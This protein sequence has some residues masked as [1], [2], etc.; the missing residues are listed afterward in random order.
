MSM[1]ALSILTP[2]NQ[3]SQSENDENI[4]QKRESSPEE[5]HFNFEPYLSPPIQSK[6]GRIAE[7]N[8][9]QRMTTLERDIK[10]FSETTL[11][12]V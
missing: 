2:I 11:K 3:F 10:D 5:A 4:P 1:Y 9:D 8:L 12:K 6:Q 7:D